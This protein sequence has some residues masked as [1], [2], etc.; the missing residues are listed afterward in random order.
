MLDALVGCDEGIEGGEVGLHGVG[1]LGVGEAVARHLVGI[2]VAEGHKVPPALDDQ[3]LVDIGHVA[4][5]GL[6]F[7]GVDVLAVGGEYHGLVSAPDVDGAVGGSAEPA[8][9]AGVQPSVAVDGG[10]CGLGVFVVALHHVEAAHDDFALWV[11]VALGQ[12]RVGHDAGLH[13]SLEC[14]ARRAGLEAAPW[15]VTDEGAALGHAEA[16]GHGEADADEEVLDLAVERGAAD[17]H[18]FEGAPEGVDEL[19]AYDAVDGLFETG[20]GEDPAYGLA[21]NHG[22]HD[23]AVDFLEDEGHADDERWAH[24]P[25][26]PEEYDGCGGLAQQCDVRADGEG[27]EHVE[28]AAV[29]VGQGQERED[30]RVLVVELGADAEYDVAA[31]VVEG[32]HHALREAGGARCVVDDA[33]RAAVEVS[34]GDVGRG[35]AAGVS[36]AEVAREVCDD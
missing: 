33:H 6:D 22:H 11:A 13:Y 35:E 3:A 23:L 15:R 34:V 19:A 36:L 2:G 31:Q 1:E 12:S 30:A 7:L 5:F 28:G 8:H 26:G 24:L 29:G 18:L 17:N 32:E 16:D 14:A 20:H 21:G 9:V 27:H 4:Q 25:D 10:G